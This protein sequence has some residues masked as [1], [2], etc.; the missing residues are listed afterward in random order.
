MDRVHQIKGI[1]LIHNLRNG[2]KRRGFASRA[3]YILFSRI[4]RKIK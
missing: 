2:I 1:F 3:T 4:D